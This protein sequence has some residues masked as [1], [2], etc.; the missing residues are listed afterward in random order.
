MEVESAIDQYGLFAIDEER[1]R[2]DG[3]YMPGHNDFPGSEEFDYAEEDRG[4]SHPWN[5]FSTWRHFRD[6]KSRPEESNQGLMKWFPH[7]GVEA[8]MADAVSDCDKSAFQKYAHQGQDWFSHRKGLGYSGNE[9]DDYSSSARDEHIG[10]GHEP[11]NTTQPGPRQRWEEAKQWTQEW[12]NRWCANCCK[13]D[14][15]WIKKANLPQGECCESS[16]CSDKPKGGSPPQSE[17]GPPRIVF[18]PGPGS[19]ATPPP[20]PDG[21]APNPDM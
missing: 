14:G 3:T 12:L 19:G 18:A 20:D 2:P 16:M 21:M 5:P 1:R 11:D 13:K 9:L 8:D 17:N 4:W 10:R 6:L 15:K 7:R